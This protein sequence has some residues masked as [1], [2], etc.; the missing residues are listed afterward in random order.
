MKQNHIIEVLENQTLASLA[1][2]ER[3]AIEAH[4]NECADCR[5]KLSATYISEALL[6]EHAAVAFTP[7]PFFATRVLATLRER[8]PTQDTWGLGR[9]WRAAGALVSS[10]AMTVAILG[11]ISFVVPGTGSGDEQNAVSMYSSD[12]EIIGPSDLSDQT[13]DAQ[14]MRT[15]Y[16]VDEEAAR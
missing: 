3:A 10:M 4:A 15:L 14:V 5:Q 8:R 1:E 9:M 16:E 11:V 7:S 6:K 2:S 12:A 13:S